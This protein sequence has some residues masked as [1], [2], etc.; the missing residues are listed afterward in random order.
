LH[1]TLSLC[2]DEHQVHAR[3]PPPQEKREPTPSIFIGGLPVA[4]TAA[5]V[6]ASLTLSQP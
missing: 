4:T 5:E 6:G 1:L 3:K 2:C